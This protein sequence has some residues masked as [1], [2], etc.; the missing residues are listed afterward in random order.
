MG[1]IRVFDVNYSL[2]IV[3]LYGALN[4]TITFYTK[5]NGLR[6]LCINPLFIVLNKG[7]GDNKNIEIDRF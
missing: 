4:S 6:F 1:L 5:N 7:F 2:V 3:V